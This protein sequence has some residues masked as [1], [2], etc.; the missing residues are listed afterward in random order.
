MGNTMDNVITTIT[1]GDFSYIIR[2]S[3][4]ED[5]EQVFDIWYENQKYSTNRLELKDK[6]LL[7]NRLQ[8]QFSNQ[9]TDLKF[10]LADFNGRIIGYQSTNP[11]ES[12]PLLCNEIA[13]SSTYVLKEFWD[14][15]VGYNL[16]KLCLDEL[17]H[18]NIKTFL[19]KILVKN[20]AMKII[21]EK[22]GWECI[23][24]IPESIK[25]PKI[26]ELM[27]FVYNVPKM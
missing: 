19:G 7:K 20:V 21:A 12:N 13:E 15:N 17:P 10:W 18:T 3:K 22:L 1:E 5:F 26:P 24:N 9:D 6:Q 4:P 27:L 25:E 23:C 8:Y 16:M 11:T 2:Y 14:K